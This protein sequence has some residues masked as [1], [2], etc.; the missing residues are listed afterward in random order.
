MMS[1]VPAMAAQAERPPEFAYHLLR[2]ALEHFQLSVPEL[3]DEQYAEAERI[4]N[5]TFALES[6]VLASPEAA[7]VV[8]PDID[9][10]KSVAEIESR[11]ES[12]TNFIED[13][14]RN[15][16]DERVLRSALARELLFNAVME[17]VSSKIPAVSDL[18]VQIFYQWHSDRFTRP[19]TRKARH[20]LVTLNE[21]FPENTYEKAVERLQP[22]IEKLHRNPGRFKDLARKHSECP[23]ALEGGRLGEL[24]QGKLYPELDTAL[25]AM[26]EGEISDI[27]QTEIGL[28]ILYCEKVNKA[29]KVPLSRA[30]KKIRAILGQRQRRACQK[31]WLDKLQEE[32][33]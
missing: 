18:D 25:F 13:L 29:I 3:N 26:E 12:Q 24:T 21:D 1:M 7:G 9:T 10:A 22:L 2:A 30:K 27:I 15:G 14:N 28:H 6:V 33:A 8:V 32:H 31:A 23:T 11:Y 20:I 16:L 19:E 5:R 17:R 4:A